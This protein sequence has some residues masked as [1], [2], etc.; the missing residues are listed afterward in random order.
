MLN[1]L[2]VQF[3]CGAT[4]ALLF[5]LALVMAPVYF[6]L[7]DSFADQ[8][9][10]ILDVLIQNDGD[11]PGGIEAG[12][13]ESFVRLLPEQQY[14]T[15]YFSVRL[16]TDGTVADVNTQYM[17]TVDEEA[18][19][20][21]AKETAMRGKTEGRCEYND[22]IYLYKIRRDS[23]GALCVFVDCTSRIWIIRQAMMYLIRVGLIILLIFTIVLSLLSRRIV[24]PFIENNERQKRFITNAGH[25]LKTPLSVISANTEMQEVETGKSKWTESTMR[26]VK[27]LNALVSELVTLSR[28]D[29]KDEIELSDVDVSAIVREQAENFEQVVVSQGKQWEQ[30][31]EEG[32]V[33]HAEKRSVQELCSILLDNAAK[34]CDEGGIVRLKL[35][36]KAS[37]RSARLYVI[38]SYA[39]GAGVDYRR[40]FDRFYREDESHNSK[41]SGFGIGL[42]MAQEIARRLGAKIQVSYKGGEIQF[43]IL[44]K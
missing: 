14:E 18:A 1:R 4:L 30:E 29:E 19:V 38:N 33:I 39:S 2:R 13:E 26:Q 41:K 28:L 25:E 37:G 17:F 43:A 34:Y 31:I 5:A 44:F 21:I 24:E 3:V 20:L 36:G 23:D 15:R 42:S 6:L 40:F 10:L 9:E 7:S 12:K 8:I 32:L 16:E 27:R 11:M 35:Q 22:G